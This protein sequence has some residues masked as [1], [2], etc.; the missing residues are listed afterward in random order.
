MAG[1]R[2]QE[3]LFCF[4]SIQAKYK[5]D[6]KLL[7]LYPHDAATFFNKEVLVDC[8][9]ELYSANVD[10]RALSYFAFCIMFLAAQ[11]SSIPLVVRLS[12]GRSKGFVK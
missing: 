4:K 6:K 10:A 7:I 2:P 8:M 12:V 11:S 5:K 3:H 9:S 1:H